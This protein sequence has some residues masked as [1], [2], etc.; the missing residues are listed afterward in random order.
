MSYLDVEDEHGIVF[1][2]HIHGLTE[3]IFKRKM[4]N[5]VS[6]H[7]TRDGFQKEYEYWAALWDQSFKNPDAP[8]FVDVENL[9][10]KIHPEDPGLDQ[11]QRKEIIELKRG[12]IHDIKAQ[13]REIIDQE[14]FPP[15]EKQ[16]KAMYDLGYEYDMH[17]IYL[18]FIH[19]IKAEWNRRYEE[20]QEPWDYPHYVPYF[21]KHCYDTLQELWTKRKA[22][23]LALSLVK[24]GLVSHGPL[25]ETQLDNG[26][27]QAVLNIHYHNELNERQ[28]PS[29]QTEEDIQGSSGDLEGNLMDIGEAEIDANEDHM[30]SNEDQMD[31]DHEEI[32]TDQ[33]DVSSGQ[34]GEDVARDVIGTAEGIE[35][36]EEAL[37][38]SAHESARTISEE[39]AVKSSETLKPDRISEDQHE[40]SETP[41]T[42]PS[43]ENAEEIERLRKESAKSTAMKETGIKEASTQGVQ[44]SPSVDCSPLSTPPDSEDEKSKKAT[45]QNT[46]GLD[47]SDGRQANLNDGNIEEV[48]LSGSEADYVT[49]KEDDEEESVCQEG[50]SL[51]SNFSEFSAFSQDGEEMDQLLAR[52]AN[53]DTDSDT[54]DIGGPKSESMKSIYRPKNRSGSKRP[55]EDDSELE[56]GEIVEETG[57]LTPTPKGS[58]EA[59]IQVDEVAEMA[60]SPYALS[61]SEEEIEI[62]EVND[63]AASFP[64]AWFQYFEDEVDEEAVDLVKI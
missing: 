19:Y 12:M 23:A 1:L 8:Y 29:P 64:L 30:D 54:T 31:I 10:I 2:N 16:R 43:R 52:A 49:A 21:M 20:T 35:G 47:R 39:V 4:C 44:S 59:A 40:T 63:D 57:Y 55:R 51:C 24:R 45:V 56:E 6:M 18:V 17:D 11:T 25:T 32:G 22:M 61:S 34:I 9:S 7:L 27:F 26:H 58:A 41:E 15:T 28:L 13:L 37:E 36:A 38:A 50:A 5:D 14:Q 60:N 46:E 42:P 48:D 33:P 53:S 62:R 3:N